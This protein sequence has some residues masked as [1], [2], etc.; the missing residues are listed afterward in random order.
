VPLA[1]AAAVALLAL[2]APPGEAAAQADPAVGPQ[3]AGF[4][5]DARAGVVIPAGE[6]IEVADAG[7]TLGADVSYHIDRRF[8]L[9]GG[10]DVQ[11]LAGAT[12]DFGTTFPDLRVF[13]AAVGGELN[14][15][16]GYD[17]RDDPDPTPFITT[18]RLGIGLTDFS[19]EATLDGGG[20]SP[21]DFDP[22]ELSFQGG[23][24]A[25]YQASSRVKVYLGST[26]HLAI[27]DRADSGAYA[28][29]SPEVDA[30]DAA[31]LVPVHAG[32]R[33]TTR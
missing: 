28:E 4:G 22:T 8:G 2:I 24:T 25:G 23:L 11:W 13:H 15:F 29:L 5:F 10:V 7:A 3:P 6:L 17:V 32:L 18:L 26:V 9:W 19:T 12:D 31:W 20:P 30:F 33:F 21:V 27:T 14:V 16:S 1:A